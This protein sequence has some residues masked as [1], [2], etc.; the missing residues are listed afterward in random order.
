M[1]TARRSHGRSSS[2]DEGLNVPPRP[3]GIV[4]RRKSNLK[5]TSLV[6]VPPEAE[7]SGPSVGII[8]TVANDS[9]PSLSLNSSTGG[10]LARRSASIERSEQINGDRVEV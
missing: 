2:I 8:E 4:I 1:P 10:P 3:S 6:S 5:S 7:I 9:S